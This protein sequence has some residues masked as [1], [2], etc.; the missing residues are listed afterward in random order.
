MDKKL[1]P[2][3][4]PPKEK[5]ISPEEIQKM[6]K[7]GKKVLAV[8]AVSSY[9]VLLGINLIISIETLQEEKKTAKK[10]KK[11]QATDSNWDKNF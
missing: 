8:L 1:K 5:L 4:I 7:L 9:L 2:P 3:L 6:E 11:E 10:Y